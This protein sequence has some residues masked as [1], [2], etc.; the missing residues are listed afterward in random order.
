MFGGKEEIV[1]LEFENHFIGVVMDRFGKDIS[2]RKKDAQH[3]YVRVQVAL[4][5][6]FYGWMTG[7]G[8]GAKITAPADVVEEYRGYLHDVSSQYNL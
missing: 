5:G 7:L 3:F 8:V 1:T 2:V 4:S 6:Q